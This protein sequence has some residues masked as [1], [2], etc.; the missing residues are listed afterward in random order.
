VFPGHALRRRCDTAPVWLD[1][2]SELPARF[3]CARRRDLGRLLVD[4]RMLS[5]TCAVSKPRTLT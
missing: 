4:L 5:L 1:D 2:V 3:G